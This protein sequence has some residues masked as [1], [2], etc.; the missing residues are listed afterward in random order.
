MQ[1]L[2]TLNQQLRLLVGCQGQSMQHP[3]SPVVTP[4][5]MIQPVTD[6]I[7]PIAIAASHAIPITKRK[8]HWSASSC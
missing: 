6:V 1:R 8:R 2:L 7:H 4:Q 3:G 5:S